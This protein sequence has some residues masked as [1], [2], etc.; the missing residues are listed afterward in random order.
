[1]NKYIVQ[2]FKMID[3][4]SVLEYDIAHNIIWQ[5][6]TEKKFSNVMLRLQKFR[7]VPDNVQ[8]RS[9]RRHFRA[10]SGNG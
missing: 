6:M 7:K 4:T 5:I 9:R 2:A 3:T 1:M 8:N 10:D